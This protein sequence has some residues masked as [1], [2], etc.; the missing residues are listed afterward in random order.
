MISKEVT[1][2]NY[3][4]IVKDVGVILMVVGHSGCWDL[5]F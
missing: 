1:H 3:I 4:V 5:L 2:Y